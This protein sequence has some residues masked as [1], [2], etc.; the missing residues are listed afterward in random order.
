MSVLMGNHEHRGGKR[1]GVGWTDRENEIEM[2]REYVIRGERGIR[3]ENQRE[4][5][6]LYR[7]IGDSK[8][9]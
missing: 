9:P 3:R 6:T 8:S 2:E 7:V 4:S 1:E 5:S